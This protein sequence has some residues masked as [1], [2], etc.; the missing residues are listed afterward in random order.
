MADVAGNL[1]LLVLMIGLV[2]S[3]LFARRLPISQMMK[4][5]AA[6]ALIFFAIFVLFSFRAEVKMV[7]ERV[8]TEAGFGTQVQADG[9][10]RIT[11]SADGHFHIVADV[12]GHPVEFLV[13]SGATTTALSAED[14]AKAGVRTP[15][16]AF[17]VIVSTAN[18]Q[19]EM[20]R[21]RVERLTIGPIVRDDFGVLI[22]DRLGG[23]NL[24]GMNFLST[25]K[26]W[27]IEGDVMIL[28][29]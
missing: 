16:L 8:K 20:Q 6:W 22:S 7:W 4:M 10:V 21:G 28:T 1:I 26:G 14:A 12:N 9:T 2:L 23:T 25:L 15:P 24:L 5:L 19:V 29:P 3:S 11:K 27:R 18:G 17:P 13:D